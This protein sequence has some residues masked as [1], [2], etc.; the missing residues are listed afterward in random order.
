MTMFQTLAAVTRTM[1][2]LKGRAK[3]PKTVEA[4]RAAAVAATTDETQ[5]SL[6]DKTP[7][8]RRHLDDLARAVFAGKPYSE[9]IDPTT[10]AAMSKKVRALFD[11]ACTPASA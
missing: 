3:P 4:L 2:Q 9:V 7:G 11:D 6:I 10:A 8:M 1:V 5:K